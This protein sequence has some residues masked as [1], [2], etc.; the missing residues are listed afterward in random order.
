[1]AQNLFDFAGTG[2]RSYTLLDAN[3][4]ENYDLRNKVWTPAYAPAT[5]AFAIDASLRTLFGF[6]SAITTRVSSSNITPTVQ[7]AGT[8]I[9]TSSMGAFAFD[10]VSGSTTAYYLF[11]RSRNATV[12][13]HTIVQS[14]DA[15][16]RLSMAGSDGAKFVE[17]A[18]IAVS[19]DGTPGTDSMPGQLAFSTT[20]TSGVTPTEAMRI[21]S[22][23]AVLFSSATG[24]F[25]YR[26]GAGGT[27]TQATSKSTGVTL[28]KVCGEITMNAASLAAGTAVSFTLTNTAISAGDRI[29]LNHMSGGTFGAYAMDARASAG[30]AT[31]M[32]RNLTAGALAE[33]VV[34]GFTVVRSA[35]T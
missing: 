3:F 35:T 17:A 26:S 22:T 13:S 28:S 4:T 20:A 6:N 25:G 32:V 29:V 21:D 30:S 24:G 12:G 18:R 2:N 34:I 7:Q 15:L 14:G 10:S 33:A 8:S 1:M 5:Y 27:V 23:Q 31:V 16:G 9:A 19:V 11:A